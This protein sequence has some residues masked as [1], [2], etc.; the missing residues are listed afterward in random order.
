MIYVEKYFDALKTRVLKC[1][2]FKLENII[3]V[4]FLQKKYLIRV[5]LVKKQ[6]NIFRFCYSLI[7][8]LRYLVLCIN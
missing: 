7:G 2:K 4:L 6:E 5:K 1:F 8:M 3:V